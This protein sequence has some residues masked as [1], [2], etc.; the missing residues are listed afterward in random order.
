MI[1]YIINNGKLVGEEKLIP[2][3]SLVISNGKIISLELHDSPAA[4]ESIN[5]AG[6]II[7]PGLIDLHVHGGVGADV[8][9]CDPGSLQRIADYHGKHGTTAMLATIAPSRTERMALALETAAKSNT[10]DTGSNIIGANLE[11]PFLNRSHNGALG[12][13][14]LREPDEKEMIELLAA[15]QGKVRIVSLAPELK[16]CL[17]VVEMLSSCGVIPSLGHSGA[18]FNETINAARAGLKHITH[19]FNAMSSMHHR[20]PGPAG[21]AFISHELSVEVIADGIHVHPA[22]LNLLYRIKGDRLVLVSDAIAAAGLPDGDYRFGGQE[23]V[24]KGSRAEIPGGRLAGST[25]TILDAVKN[26]IKFAGLELTQAVRLASTNPAS[27]LGLQKKG[28]IAPGFDAD[29]VLL[30]ANLDPFLVMVE[31][32][33]I[34]RKAR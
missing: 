17:K 14:F 10:S 13:P 27:V 11:G 23:I 15:G 31:G 30:D 3:R 22:M 32:R 8:L 19:I 21:A 16:G 24:V 12:I 25:I 1:D 26:I 4:I 9:D 18:T 2:N 7:A 6:L 34:F 29:L 5:A 20:E 33:V 28:R